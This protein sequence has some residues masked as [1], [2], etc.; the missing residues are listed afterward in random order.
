MKNQLYFALLFLGIVSC[1]DAPKLENE[2]GKKTNYDVVFRE[3]L[4]GK[5]EKWEAADN[6]FK[7]FYTYTD[8]GRGPE[9]TEEIKL[10]SDNYIISESI[11]G[12]NYLKDSISE[13][14]NGVD[15]S[16]SWKNPMSED[17]ADFNGK[18]LYFRHDGS[19]AVYEI[20]AQLLT[21]S[22]NSKV[23]LYPEGEVEL[24][25]QYSITLSDSTSLNLL[26]IK[27]LEMIPRYLWMKNNE[28]V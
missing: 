16:A 17:K 23:T 18:A 27:G 12:V 6:S 2:K 1:S 25:D 11:T 24:V 3:K 19:P 10:N 7:Y 4:A 8:R 9:V 13:N 15:G 26:M 21:A 5:Y 22:E 14:F 20:I 28:M